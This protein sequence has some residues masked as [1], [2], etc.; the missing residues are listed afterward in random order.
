MLTNTRVCNVHGRWASFARMEQWAVIELLSCVQCLSFAQPVLA[1]SIEF[2]TITFNVSHD[3][4]YCKQTPIS[5]RKRLYSWVNISRIQYEHWPVPKCSPLIVARD[6]FPAAIH[7]SM[8]ILII[9]FF[10]A[11]VESKNS[12][13][14]HRDVFLNGMD[15]CRNEFDCYLWLLFACNPARMLFRV[16][17]FAYQ[18][19]ASC[20]TRRTIGFYCSRWFANRTL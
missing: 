18:L 19:L 20:G 8:E 12:V 4:F 17:L 6:S 11:I 15:S 16:R 9:S 2:A 5:S 1:E 7:H 13:R 14:V 10:A 3:S